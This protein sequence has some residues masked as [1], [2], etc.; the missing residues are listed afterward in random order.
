LPLATPRP[1]QLRDH[2]YLALFMASDESAHMTGQIVTVDDGRLAQ[3]PPAQPPRP[4]A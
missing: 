2:A 4:P 1:V 3:M